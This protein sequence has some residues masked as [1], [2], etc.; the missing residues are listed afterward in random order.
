MPAGS[1][2]R[3]ILALAAFICV[4]SQNGQAES[5]QHPH[6]HMLA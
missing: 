6:A 2:N 1:G 3:T 4:R 5:Q